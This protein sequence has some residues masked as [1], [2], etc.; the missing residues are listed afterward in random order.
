MRKVRDEKRTA[1]QIEEG[2]LQSETAAQFRQLLSECRFQAC[3]F[4]FSKRKDLWK[5][6]VNNWL[7]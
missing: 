1:I 3:L 7:D 5:A 4:T 2:D 6:E